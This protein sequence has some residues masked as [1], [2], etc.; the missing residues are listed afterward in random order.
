MM[1]E[2]FILTLSVLL[3]ISLTLLAIPPNGSLKFGFDDVLAQ[4]QTVANQTTGAT[5]GQ[6]Q[7]VANQ[8]T[9]A[10]AGQNQTAANVTLQEFQPLEDAF[11][12]AR[13]AIQENNTGVAY[14]ALSSA[15]DEI[16]DLTHVSQGETQGQSEIDKAKALEERL[17]PI[18]DSV[19]DAKE[20]IWN[21]NAQSS[22][23]ALGSGEVSLLEITRS[24]PTGEEEGE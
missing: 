8:T 7:T 17:K 21:D 2:K 4:N 1:F 13:T 10:T 11:N 5:A 24:L 12:E 20:A 22:L 14:R 18:R 6:N 23:N 3:G 9:G 15:Q 19:D 16:F